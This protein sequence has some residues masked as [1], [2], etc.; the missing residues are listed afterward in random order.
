MATNLARIAKDRG[1]RYFLVSFVDLF[2]GTRAKLVPARAIGDMQKEGAGFA[3][4]AAWLD[5]TPADPD[6]F[7]IPDPNSLAQLPWK[8][9]VAWV[10]ADLWMNGK[11]VEASQSHP[12]VPRIDE[13]QML[14]CVQL[15]QA[16]GQIERFQ[17]VEQH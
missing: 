1:I 17:H 16:V 15:A 14:V 4:F 11:E 12:A 7:A 13:R 6:M 2:G 5:M 8:P 3:G 10:A 9:E